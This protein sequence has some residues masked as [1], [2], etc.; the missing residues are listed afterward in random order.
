MKQKRLKQQMLPQHFELLVVLPVVL[1]QQPP[2][3][4]PLVLLPPV[5]QL[6][7]LRQL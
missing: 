5:Q 6:L 4:Q 1:F 3:Q 2:V 7:V